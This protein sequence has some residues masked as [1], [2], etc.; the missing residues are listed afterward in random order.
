M[1]GEPTPGRTSAAVSLSVVDAATGELLT[2]HRGDVVRSTASVG[3]LLLL[4]ELA[5]RLE[6]DAS[7]GTTVLDRRGLAP[8]GDSGLWQHL[9]A[10]TLTAGDAATLVGAVSDNVATNALL[11]L[12]GL[13]AVERRATAYGL[14]VTRLHDVVRDERRPGHPERLSSG[15]TDEL[16]G[17]M[18]RLWRDRQAAG[19]R[20]LA[21]LA[22]G[23]DLSMVPAPFGLDPLAHGVAADR[24]LRVWSK[25]GTDAGVRADVGLVAGAA[26]VAAY[27]VVANWRVRAPDDPDRDGVLRWLHEVG[28]ALRRAVAPAPTSG[29]LGP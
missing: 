22:G 27:A 14:A 24:G 15:S 13:E 4:A 25:T 1:P 7:V 20:V 8:V 12:V 11:G 29:R 10:D 19:G 26:G 2:S 18:V 21:W 16:A 6:V 9:A 28:A 5:E 17:L 3:K 23:A